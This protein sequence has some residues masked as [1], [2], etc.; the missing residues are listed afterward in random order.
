M[1]TNRVGIGLSPA[2]HYVVTR[3]N[4]L[5]QVL[6][7][8]TAQAHTLPAGQYPMSF[9]PDNEYLLVR[10]QDGTSAVYS[11]ETWGVVRTGPRAA[12]FPALHANGTTIAYLASDPFG[13][14]PDYIRFLDLAGGPV[15]SPI[16]LPA[17]ED[18]NGLL[19]DRANHLDIL[20]RA[21]SGHD[22]VWR[23]RRVNDGMRL[24]D[25]FAQP[26]SETSV[27][28]ELDVFTGVLDY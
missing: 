10:Q 1:L 16:K 15:S 11:T 18:G 17:G 25:T 24:L 22:L 21:H 7:S 9:S 26:P 2:G 3:R 28:D 27:D 5:H 6:N 19:W 12:Y 4:E 20:T 23:W 8:V 14:E 13:K